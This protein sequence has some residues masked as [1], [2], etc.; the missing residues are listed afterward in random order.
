MQL[1]DQHAEIFEGERAFLTGLAYRMLG[2]R[3]EAED[4]VQDA[5]LR[6]TRVAVPLPD[7]PRAWLIRVTSRLCIDRLR[8]LKRERAVYTGPWLPEPWLG[9][10]PL[11]A[12]NA[13]ETLADSLRLAFLLMLER[14][15]PAERAAFLLREAFGL[16]YQEIAQTLDRSETACRQLVSRAKKH[17]KLSSKPQRQGTQEFQLLQSFMG[18]CASGNLEQLKS[19]LAQDVELWSDGGGKRLAALNVVKSDDKVARFLLGISTKM[20][21]SLQ[22]KH[23]RVNQMPGFILYGSDGVESLISIEVREDRIARVYMHRNPDKLRNLH[24]Q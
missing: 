22:V 18:A 9:E 2:E 10:D 1:N 8:A 3:S 21:P 19:I 12:H 23:A 20:T 15:S 5:Y 7:N 14:M 4:I 6:W 11:S 13:M 16:S 24:M 17:L